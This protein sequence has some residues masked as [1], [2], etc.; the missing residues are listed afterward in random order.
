MPGFDTGSVMY[1]LNVDFTGNSLTSGTAQVTTN[2]QL[3]IGSTA[4][5]NIRVGNLT[6]TGGTV[7]ITNG[8]GTINLEAGPVM[9]TTYTEDTGSAIPAANILQIRGGPGVTTTG[10]GNTVTINSVVF[11]DQ[12]GSTGVLSDTGSFATGAITLTTPAIPL[13]GELL[14]FCCTT[15]SALVVTAAGAQKIRIGSLVSS[16]GGTATSTAIGD[17]ITLRF[18][19]SDSI[20]YATSSIGT[21]LMA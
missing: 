9:A 17:S 13:Q 6:S 4:A 3:L 14:Q 10:S 12:G 2:G 15:A 16:A 7:T 11:T 20:W 21:W 19:A 8:A 1:A 18:R 5:P